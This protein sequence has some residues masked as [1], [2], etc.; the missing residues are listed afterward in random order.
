MTVLE[1]ITLVTAAVGASLGI[2]NTWTDFR[3]NKERIRVVPNHAILHSTH[4][5]SIEI[6]NEGAVA[7]TIS[8]VGLEL[9]TRQHLPI[10]EENTIAGP[11]LPFRLDPRDSKTFYLM[12]WLL[13]S[14][15]FRGASN[16]YCRTATGKKFSGSSDA[17]KQLVREGRRH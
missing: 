10:T 7:V 14:P 17:L 11:H 4:T 2:F 15:E 13:D 12:P 9:E 3:R 1:T 8:G 6:I 5:A 16:A